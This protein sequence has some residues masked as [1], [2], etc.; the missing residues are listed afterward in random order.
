[1]IQIARKLMVLRDRFLSC[2][3]VLEVVAKW[4]KLFRKLSDEVYS[5]RGT[6]IFME[7]EIYYD[8]ER[9]QRLHFMMMVLFYY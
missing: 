6:V 2:D 3:V 1:M 9:R 8:F 5:S 4:L 7:G